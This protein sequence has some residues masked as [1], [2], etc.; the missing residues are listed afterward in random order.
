[1]SIDLNKCPKC[2]GPADNGHD[3]CLPP[4]PYYCT[5][6]TEF[7]VADEESAK[8]THQPD[9]YTDACHDAYNEYKEKWQLS[10]NEPPDYMV[11]NDAW[12]AA[13]THM[14]NMPAGESNKPKVCKEILSIMQTYHEQEAR[15]NIGTPGGLE[16]MGDVWKLFQRW[17]RDLRN[18]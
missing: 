13:I 8:V 15:G 18:D 4:N 10:E 3:R 16:H 2:G 6:C 11:W 9:E 17:E 12:I 7:D 14:G 1:M 5:K